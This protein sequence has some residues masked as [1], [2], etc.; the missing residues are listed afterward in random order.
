MH[1]HCSWSSTLTFTVYFKLHCFIGPISN[2]ST[3]SRKT[4]RYL[5][6]DPDEKY[7]VNMLE[8]KQRRTLIWATLY[9]SLLGW[10]LGSIFHSLSVFFQHCLP[11]PCSLAP[12]S[13]FPFL[14][15]TLSFFLSFFCSFFHSFFR[16]FIPPFF[17][18][19]HH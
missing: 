6:A 15:L 11:H 10:P 14:N 17:P 8:V 2:N 13:P 5:C 19:L 7:Q 4:H 18:K 9:T 1:L 3:N 16:S 12:M